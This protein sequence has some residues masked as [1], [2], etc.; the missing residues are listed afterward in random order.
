MKRHQTVVMLLTCTLLAGGGCRV[1]SEGHPAAEATYVGFALD[2]YP[3]TEER[4]HGLAGP[5]GQR[6]DMV[7]FYLQWP[8]P[9][10]LAGSDFPTE[11][12]EAIHD[13]GSMPCI[14]WEPMYIE[15]GEEKTIQASVVTN[16][17]YDAYIRTFARQAADWGKPVLVR[18]A[19]EMN[20]SRYHW[21][22]S[23]A[24]YGPD[25]PRLY[26]A[27]FRYVV[28]LCR[29]AG[30]TNILW[31]FCPNAESV[32]APSQEDATTW[33]RMLSYYPGDAYVD[34]LGVDGYNWGL[35]RN[36]KEHGWTSRPKTFRDIF[37]K[38]VRE[39]TIVAPQKPVIVFE[40]ASVGDTSEKSEWLRKA[41][42]ASADLDI[43]G[44]IWFQVD[45]E[46]YW[47]LPVEVLYGLKKST[48]AQGRNIHQWIKGI[49]K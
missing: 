7:M 41:F 26:T 21:G 45:K 20:I 49:Q 34:V 29:D 25:S 10:N 36:T 46:T 9:A 17:T 1:M 47:T 39:L 16:G 31:V 12:V 27:L 33:N 8:S 24:D 44:I 32:P 43:H 42:N 28:E 18:F 30:N 15:G 22:T 3:I 35:S 5:Q 11:S 4:L 38:P 2:G 48:A 14:T 40:T 6:P 37:E 19:H 23:E 13:A